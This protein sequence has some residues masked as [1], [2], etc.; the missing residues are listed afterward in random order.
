ML[1][2]WIDDEKDEWEKYFE[3]DEVVSVREWIATVM[4]MVIPGSEHRD[5]VL[6]GVC[7]QDRHPG[8]QS[9]LGARFAHRAGDA[10]LCHGA[11]AGLPDVGAVYRD[12]QNNRFINHKKRKRY[13]TNH[14]NDVDASPDGGRN[15]GAGAKLAQE[16]R[17]EGG[18]KS[19]TEGGRESRESRGQ[20]FR[21]GGRRRHGCR[22]GQRKEGKENK[23]ADAG[24]NA[25]A[26]GQEVAQDGGQQQKKSAQMSWNKFDYVSGDEIMF[27]DNQANEQIGEFPSMWD[28]MKGNAEIAAMDNVKCINLVGD[29]KSSLL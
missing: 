18:R 10:A 16:V 4:L 29:T 7:R 15:A 1:R 20:G 21:Q 3:N 8:Q 19:Q 14:Y 28:L 25:D 12:R 27:E 5:A 26:D 23:N 24:D 17:Q 2:K 11:H 22:N 13:E 6:V 9:E